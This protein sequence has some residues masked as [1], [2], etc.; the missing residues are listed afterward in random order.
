MYTSISSCTPNKI[1]LN[2]FN[3]Q[4]GDTTIT[5]TQGLI[6]PIP[7][8]CKCFRCFMRIYI[9]LAK[10]SECKYPTSTYSSVSLLIGFKWFIVVWRVHISIERWITTSIWGH[11]TLTIL[12]HFITLFTF[13][14]G[15]NRATNRHLALPLNKKARPVLDGRIEKLESVAK[16]ESVSELSPIKAERN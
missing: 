1:Y 8:I 12:L 13:V 7:N 2:L 9:V 10:E 4:L 6:N 5:R 11:I 14:G 3:W 15:P 16:T